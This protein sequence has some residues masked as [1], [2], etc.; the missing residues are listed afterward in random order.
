MLSR[1]FYFINPDNKSLVCKLYS[2]TPR[3]AALKAATY[4]VCQVL[5]IVEIG[6]VHVFKGSRIPLKEETTFTQSKHIFTKPQV[7]KVLSERIDVNIKPQTTIGVEHIL[8]IVDPV[9]GR[10]SQHGRG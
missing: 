1:T 5:L 6:K 9:L 3:D 7:A 10:H 4:G 8:K 2:K